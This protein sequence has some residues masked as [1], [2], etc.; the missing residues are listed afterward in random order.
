MTKQ[1]RL[2]ELKKETTKLGVNETIEIP[3]E[4]IIPKFKPISESNLQ[5]MCIKW[6]YLKFPE[7]KIFSIPNGGSRNIV[8]A[9][10]MK[11]EGVL[12]GVSDLFFPKPSQGKHGLF[13]E[14]KVGYNKPTEKQKEF[15]EYATSENYATAVIYSFE[16]FEKLINDYLGI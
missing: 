9:K 3:K 7:Y 16:E 1:K 2:V 6:F 4:P 14:M 10:K 11:L 15:M 5:K 12:A 8:E 13:I